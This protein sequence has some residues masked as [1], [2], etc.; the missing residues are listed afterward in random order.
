MRWD[1][2]K[3]LYHNKRKNFAYVPIITD[4]CGMSIKTVPLILLAQ[5]LKSLLCYAL[6]IEYNAFFIK[7]EKVVISD[8]YICFFI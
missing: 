1:F 5:V 8:L 6:S 4:R 2:N 7:I 3:F